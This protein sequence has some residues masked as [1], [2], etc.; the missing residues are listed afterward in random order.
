MNPIVFAVAGS[1]FLGAVATAGDYIWASQSLPHK[2]LYGLVHGAAFCGA[3]GLVVGIGQGRAIA[4]FVGGLVAGVLAAASFYALAP[5]LGR[6]AVLAAWCVLWLLLACLEGPWLRK[7]KVPAALLRG[8]L[9]AAA[10]GAA[11]FYVTARVWTN[12][13]H[14]SIDLVDHFWRWTVGFLPGFVVL[15]VTLSVQVRRTSGR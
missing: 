7:A 4:G 8:G 15:L 10:S 5:A 9:A 13:H 3:M 2:M 12:W 14:G 1:L 11:F 6:S